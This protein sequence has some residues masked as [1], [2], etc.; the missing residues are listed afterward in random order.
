MAR[1]LDRSLLAHEQ[2]EGYLRLSADTYRHFW[3]L[4]GPL[5]AAETNDQD[6]RRASRE[7]IREQF[8]ALERLTIEELGFLAGSEPQERQE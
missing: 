2:T 5:I 4:A 8:R 7:R 3:Q 6:G 1:Q